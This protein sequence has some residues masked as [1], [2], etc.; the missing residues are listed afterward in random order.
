MTDDERAAFE[1]LL[2][3]GTRAIRHL[4]KAMPLDAVMS[5]AQNFTLAA[6]RAEEIL[7]PLRDPLERTLTEMDLENRRSWWDALQKTCERCGATPMPGSTK[8]ELA[9]EGVPISLEQLI[10]ELFTY[11]PPTPDQVGQY[12]AIN[13]A[14]RHF[15]HAIDENCPA[16][17]DRTF[18][19]R[20]VQLARMT[21]NSAIANRGASYR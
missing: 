18:A 11:H 12:E 14:A 21:A 6:N 9:K 5:F 16:G 2:S 17:A 19:I 1:A 7:D 15:A 20:L 10:D 8:F 3:A 4:G 13:N